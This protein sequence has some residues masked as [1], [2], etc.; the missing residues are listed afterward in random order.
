MIEIM[1]ISHYG[2]VQV[3]TKNA[4][5]DC[6]PVGFLLLEE[7]VE[8]NASKSYRAKEFGKHDKTLVVSMFSFIAHPVISDVR[9][10]V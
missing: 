8:K 6:C 1:A 4:H 5:W 7:S 10:D 2:H 9:L 3:D